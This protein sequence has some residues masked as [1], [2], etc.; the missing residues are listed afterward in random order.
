VGQDAGEVGLRVQAVAFGGGDEAV[1][2]GGVGGG[3]VV[4][5]EQPVLP[6]MPSSA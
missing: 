1:E 4:A 6:V 5:G 3:L 2:G